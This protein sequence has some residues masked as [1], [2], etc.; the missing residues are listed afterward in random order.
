MIADASYLI[1]VRD[2]WMHAI[3]FMQKLMLQQRAAEQALHIGCW[4]KPLRGRFKPTIAHSP[5]YA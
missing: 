4:T 3:S 2:H 1:T 5:K